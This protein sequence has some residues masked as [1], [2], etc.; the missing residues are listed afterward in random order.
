MLMVVVSMGG[1]GPA[2]VRAN[3]SMPQQCPGAALRHFT[4]PKKDT[5]AAAVFVLHKS[6][7]PGQTAAACAAQCLRFAECRSFSFRLH[8]GL[9]QLYTVGG[10]DPA[11]TMYAPAGNTNLYSRVTYFADCGLAEGTHM[12]ATTVAAEQHAALTTKTCDVGQPSPPSK[13]ALG[14]MTECC[15]S[16]TSTSRIFDTCVTP[17]PLHTARGILP[18]ILLHTPSPTNLQ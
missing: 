14:G 4:H 18:H 6:A 5:K 17:P 2:A 11:T 16:I 12:V 9:C 3:V 7:E 10:A 8:G 15:I 1:G 13:V